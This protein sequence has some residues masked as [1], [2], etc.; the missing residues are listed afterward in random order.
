LRDGLLTTV[1]IVGIIIVLGGVAIGPI[2]QPRHIRTNAC[3]Q[4]VHA[5]GISLYSYA[6][7]NNGAYPDGTSSTEVF[8]KLLDGGYVTDPHIFYLPI[9]GK[10][11][12]ATDQKKLKP[13]NICF[14][15][16]GG[17]AQADSPSTPL[18]FLTGGR[19]IY[20]PG[21]PAVPNGSGFPVFESQHHFMGFT[22]TSAD[23]DDSSQSGLGV[24]YVN[25]SAR[26]INAQGSLVPN[27][28]PADFDA[29]GK[30]YRQLTP[31]GV[32]K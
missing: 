10:V 12:P 2:H 9:P 18:I 1:V 19:V 23:G 15:V 7:D 6:N 26:W 32:L 5:I 13:E 25:N 14:D 4:Q 16:T 24:Y 17:V 3:V 31:T 11:E 22:W 27:F 20:A 30:T 28:V 29:H 8:Q 21:A